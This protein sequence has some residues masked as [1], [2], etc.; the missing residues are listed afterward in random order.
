[1]FVPE[2]TIE[3]YAEDVELLWVQQRIPVLHNAPNAFEF[4]RDY[5]SLS[6]PC[7]FERG[8]VDFPIVELDELVEHSNDAHV[9]VAV[10]PDGHGDCV[11][12]TTGGLMF[13]QPDEQTMSLSQ[14]R[15]HLRIQSERASHP[16]AKQHD[17]Q[18]RLFPTHPHENDRTLGEPELSLF[19][20]ICYYSRQNDCLR[21]E[22]SELWEH[23]ALPPTIQWAQD[24]F[25]TGPPDAVNLWIGN[26]CSVSA[27]H[28][29][30]YHNLFI[31]LSGEKVFTLCPPADAP[32]LYERPYPSGRFQQTTDSTWCV[33][34]APPDE[35]P[36]PWIAANITKRE[37]HLQQFPLLRYAHPVTVRVGTGQCL[38]IP[39]LWYHQVTQTCETIGVNYWYDMRFDSPDWCYFRL[40]QNLVPTKDE[41]DKNNDFTVE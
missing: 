13:V 2:A 3:S 27:M 18:N 9:M 31:V 22:L 14:L 39:P 29:D 36:V 41:N 16:A 5:V 23:L 12:K 19:H 24:A 32:F 38:Y 30:H 26:E 37:D 10:T 7:I 4:L 35:G 28:K 21:Q 25:G 15:S 1:M 33:D 34:M 40:G 17:I 6:K 11:R 8:A 20:G